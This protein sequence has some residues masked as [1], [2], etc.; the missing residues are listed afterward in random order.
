[1]TKTPAS[2]APDVVSPLAALRRHDGRIG[3]MGHVIADYPSGLAVRSMIAAMVEAGAT[4]IE[5]QIPFSEPMADGPV[6]L[7]ANH[8]ALAQGVDYA[9]CLQLMREVSAQYP[10]VSFLFMTYLNIV[11]RRGYA[12]FVAEACAAGAVGAIVPD[13]PYEYGGEFDKACV[14]HRFTNVRLIPPNCEGER[15]DQICSQATNLIYAVARA[16]VTG[17]KTSFGDELKALVG[18]IRSRTQ[19]PVAVGFGVRSATDIRMLR[20]LADLA[21]V[22]TESLKTY[23]ASGLEGFRALWQSLASATK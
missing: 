5:I 15:L 13:L 12:R 10:S 11:Y 19:A 18:R 8:K 2:S 4:V 22:G 7:A 21:V 6:F 3:L 1:M 20:G 23:D 16:G 9:S 14:A 17:A